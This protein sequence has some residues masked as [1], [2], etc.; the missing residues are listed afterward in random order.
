MQFDELISQPHSDDPH[1]QPKNTLQMLES[2]PINLHV[3]DSLESK[4]GIE[5]NGPVHIGDGDR[6]GVDAAD[7]SLLC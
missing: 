6:D 7:E 2:V 3:E 4:F 5:I 1:P